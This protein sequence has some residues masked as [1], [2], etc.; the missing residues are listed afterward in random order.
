MVVGGNEMKKWMFLL[1]TVLVVVA[2]CGNEEDDASASENEKIVKIGSSPDGYPISFQEDGEMKGFNV[3]IYIMRFL[4]NWA[5][6][7]NG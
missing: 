1:I 7:L 5:M 6:E 3:D 2:G 4:M